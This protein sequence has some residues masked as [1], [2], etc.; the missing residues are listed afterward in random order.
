MSAIQNELGCYSNVYTAGRDV[1]AS[2]RWP[3]ECRDPYASRTR[4][5]VAVDQ[6]FIECL[7]AR[8]WPLYA[9]HSD[10]INAKLKPVSEAKLLCHIGASPRGGGG[11]VTSV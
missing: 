5:V 9:V 6:R 4:D 3:I 2:D 7:L 1:I 10:Y 8:T 11:G